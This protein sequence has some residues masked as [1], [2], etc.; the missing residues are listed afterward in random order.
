MSFILLSGKKEF[1]AFYY[2][3][4]RKEKKRMT[5]VKW[6]KLYIPLFVQMKSKQNRWKEIF[7]DNSDCFIC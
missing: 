4:K 1:D 7:I 2:E 5:E 6:S 3:E